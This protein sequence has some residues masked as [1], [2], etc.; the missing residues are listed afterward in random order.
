MVPVGRAVTLLIAVVIP[1][2][3]VVSDGVEFGDAF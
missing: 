3:M 1:F 2:L